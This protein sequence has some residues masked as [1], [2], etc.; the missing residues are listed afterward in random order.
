MEN[1]IEK[2]LITK[3]K[4]IT[5][6]SNYPSEETNKYFAL[7]AYEI[8]TGKIGNYKEKHIKEGGYEV[9]G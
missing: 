6:I 5:V 2:T 3:H 9:K 7:M 1:P 8:A 4:G